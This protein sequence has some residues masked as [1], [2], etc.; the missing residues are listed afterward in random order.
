ML[1]PEKIE[2]REVLQQAVE[3]AV[4]ITYSQFRH[5][6]KH[7]G[8]TLEWLLEQAK[9]KLDKPT[10]TLRRVMHGALVDGKHELLA[11]VVIPYRCLIELYQRAT[12]L[13]PALVGD[14]MCACGCGEL[15]RGKKKWATPGCRKRVQRGV[16]DGS[17]NGPVGYVKSTG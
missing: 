9:E 10:D 8:W 14:K 15:V 4:S 1:A 13:K 17:K 3:E 6:A 16:C 7:R 11:D 12:Q 5:V 2:Q